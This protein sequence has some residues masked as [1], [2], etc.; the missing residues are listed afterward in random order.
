MDYFIQISPI[1]ASHLLPGTCVD[2]KLLI[3]YALC[4]NVIVYILSRTFAMTSVDISCVSQFFLA[5]RSSSFLLFSMDLK[6]GHFSVRICCRRNEQK[7]LKEQNLSPIETLA[8]GNSLNA[9]MSISYRIALII[10]T[11]FRD[12]NAAIVERLEASSKLKNL[13]VRWMPKS[14][15]VLVSQKLTLLVS[16]SFNGMILIDGRSQSMGSRNAAE[17]FE[18]LDRYNRLLIYYH[19]RTMNIHNLTYF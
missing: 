9:F 17:Q 13:E 2:R 8:L 15:I 11:P 19:S 10:C 16:R 4:S 12:F 14:P 6:I 7:C 18:S 1:A 5:I 3:L